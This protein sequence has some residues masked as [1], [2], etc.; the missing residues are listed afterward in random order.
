M[1]LTVFLTKAWQTEWSI[2]N[3]MQGRLYSLFTD[4][5]KLQIGKEACTAHCQ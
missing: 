3:R 5:R 4:K 2:E 1:S